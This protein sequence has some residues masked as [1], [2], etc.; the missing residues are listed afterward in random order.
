M[1]LI[2]YLKNQI[3]LLILLRTT[4]RFKEPIGFYQDSLLYL[5]NRN[6]LKKIGV[7]LN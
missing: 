7:F 4:G 1:V 3:Y 5:Q 2:D 6:T